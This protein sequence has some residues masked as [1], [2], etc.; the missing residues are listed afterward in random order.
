M[1]TSDC[2]SLIKRV[3]EEGF[4][5]EYNP[6]GDGM[7]FYASAAHQ[8][9]LSATTVKNLLF[10]YLRTHRSDVRITCIFLVFVA[11]LLLN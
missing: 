5:I 3:K 2:K 1:E 11:S 9:G 8:L 6:P 7:C 10:D 4:E